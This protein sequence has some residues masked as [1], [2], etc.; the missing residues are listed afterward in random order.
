M[1]SC[2]YRVAFYEKLGSPLETV[3][4]QLVAWLAALDAVIVHME[5]FYETGN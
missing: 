5:K 3:E 4:V 2:P 1:K